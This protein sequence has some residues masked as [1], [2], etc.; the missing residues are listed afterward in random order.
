MTAVHT[1]VAQTGTLPGFN[2]RR[3]I[4][5]DHN[6]VPNTDQTSFPVLISG[7]FSYLASLAHSGKV[8]NPN[9][10]DIVFTDSTGT[11]LLNWEIESY[12]PTDGSVTIWV[13]IPSLSHTVDTVLYVYYGNTSISTFQGGAAGTVWDSNYLAVYH[14]SGN[15]ACASAS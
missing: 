10:L 2:Y 15:K 13:K 4:T 11:Q 6:K 7:T 9:G 8:T 14:Q 12:S 3:A 1:V 5:I